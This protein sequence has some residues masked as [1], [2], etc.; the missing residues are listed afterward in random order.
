LIKNQLGCLAVPGRTE[1]LEGAVA[2]VQ[3]ESTVPTWSTMTGVRAILTPVTRVP[4]ST[5]ALSQSFH[6]Q[7]AAT[8]TSTHGVLY[9]PFDGGATK[10]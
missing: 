4:R 6:S 9:I 1:A 5:Q 8:C 7:E 3:T 2:C 10:Q